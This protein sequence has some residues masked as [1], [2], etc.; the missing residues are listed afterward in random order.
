MIISS[1]KDCN[2]FDL[3]SLWKEAFG[4]TDEVIDSF[5]STAF[6]KDRCRCIE[7]NGKVIAA[8]YWF[9]CEYLDR[10]IAYLYAIATAK[11][12]QGKGICTALMQS[13]HKELEKLSYD[14]A[15][16]VPACENLF[17]F[18]KQLGYK[19]KCFINEFEVL[20]SDKVGLR[21]IDKL[22]F[23]TLRKN[24]LPKNSI[25]QDGENLDFFA[26]ACDFYSGDDF[27]FAA[28]KKDNTL[29]VAEFLGN[30]DTAAK[31]VATF[32]CEKGVFRTIG[33][34]KP[35]ALWLPLGNEKLPCPDYFGL[36]FDL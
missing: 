19:D 4:D 13:V 31:I 26:T 33:D 27:I 10:K 12:E 21:K 22:E 7:K 2:I 25:I 17:A 34:S 32:G 35:F 24:L 18:Y 36:A 5:F 8:L 30:V 15:I 16:L 14:G 9:D 23:G 28:Y 29:Y 1:P 3:K 20:P 11:S 6:S